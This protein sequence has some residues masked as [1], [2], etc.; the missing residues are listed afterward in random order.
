M[1]TNGRHLQP[2][3]GDLAAVM[4]GHE[5]PLGAPGA[6]T[7]GSPV[8]IMPLPL[9]IEV[10]QANMSDGTMGVVLYVHTPMGG[11]FTFILSAQVAKTLGVQLNTLASSAAAGLH[12]PT[13]PTL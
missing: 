1:G 9:H 4:P 3:R 5:A 2:V 8:P 10:G 12:V 6:F 13:E 7:D 11:P